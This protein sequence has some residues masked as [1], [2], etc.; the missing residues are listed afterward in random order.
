M[1]V[2][3]L[4]APKFSGTVPASLALQHP[5]EQHRQY[6]H[7]EGEDHDQALPA[8]ACRLGAEHTPL[9]GS[10]DENLF[11]KWLVGRKGSAVRLLTAC[12]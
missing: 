1:S 6:E 3:A 4:S 2:A 5:N 9:F 10:A 11:F 8:S 7:H 12:V